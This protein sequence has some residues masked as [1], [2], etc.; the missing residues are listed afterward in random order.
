MPTKKKSKVTKGDLFEALQ[1]IRINMK[2]ITTNQIGKQWRANDTG[3]PFLRAV[4][5]D[6][7]D[8]SGTP[9][10]SRRRQRERHPSNRSAKS[11]ENK[12]DLS[13]E[14]M[15]VI[16]KRVTS[17]CYWLSTQNPKTLKGVA[18]GYITATLSFA[19]A[20]ISDTTVCFNYKEC[21][22]TCLFH[23]GRGQMKNVRNARIKKTNLF[24]DN[25]EDAALEIHCEIRKINNRLK[26]I[27]NS[28]LLAV[29]LNCFS[30]LKWEELR[31]DSLGG[32]TLFEA[33]PEVQFYDYTKIP[34]GYR[35]A[36]E[37]MPINYHLTYS[38][39]GT[40][41]GA[42]Y[43][44]EILDMGYNIAV[45][46]TKDNYKLFIKNLEVTKGDSLRKH[47]YTLMDNEVSDNRFLDPSPVI[48]I[49]REKGHSNIAQ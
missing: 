32:E 8:P 11:P 18:D 41:R 40:A 33:N 23:Q 27:P 43:A 24:F 35:D 14:E 47:S 1:I 20:D 17:G 6:W 48:L 12:G 31:F 19:P 28:P 38:W 16:A 25:K 22:D 49:G 45:V 21:R 4:F 10:H 36:W 3:R 34:K 46:L 37:D 9:L 44:Q 13:S 30:D 5:D 15:G 39:D 26:R 29:R 42:D 7:T 2:N